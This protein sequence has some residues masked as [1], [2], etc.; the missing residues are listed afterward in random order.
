MVGEY[1]RRRIGTVQINARFLAE[2]LRAFGLQYLC[3]SFSLSPFSLTSDI[4]IFW[5]SVFLRSGSNGP[6]CT[7]LVLLVFRGFR[8]LNLQIQVIGL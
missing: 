3:V 7:G 5:C 6:Q 2:K 4:S 8:A 1:N